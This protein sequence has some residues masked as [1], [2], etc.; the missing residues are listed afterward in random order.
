MLSLYPSL[1]SLPALGLRLLTWGLPAFAPPH[2]A[3]AFGLDTPA[4][5]PLAC[6]LRAERALCVCE[7][8]Y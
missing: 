3:W 7:R 8:L 1:R 6:L 2:F 5:L 4:P